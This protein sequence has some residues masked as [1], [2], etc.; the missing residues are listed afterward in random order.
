VGRHFAFFNIPASGHLIP[1]L[2]IAEELV[3]RGHRVTYA[4]TAEFAGT[5]ASTGASVLEYTST[6]DP[7]TIAPTG[8]DDWLARVLLGAA[9]EAIATAPAF[10]RHFANDPPDLVAYDISMQF[11]GRVLARKWQ[12]PSVQFYPVLASHQYFS[13]AESHGEGIFGDFM[14]ELRRFAELHDMADVPLSALVS[15]DAAALKVVTMP[16][17]FQTEAETFGDDYKFVG[18]TLRERDLRGTWQP[19]QS[20]HPVVLISLGTTFNKQLGFFRMCAEAFAGLP[21]HVVIAAGPGVDLA[22]VG[23]L[24]PNA[25]IHSWLS[26]QA[27]L[28]HAGAF[29][30]HGGAGSTMNG[31]YAGVPL[32]AIPQNG[33][34]QM[35]ADRTAELGLGRLLSSSQVTAESL[36]QAVLE[37]AAD[38]AT[39]ENVQRMRKHMHDAGGAPRAAD[40]ILAYLDRSGR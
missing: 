6:L 37:I 11:L 23:P 26:L 35:I 14:R 12:L 10:E 39:Q 16:K 38:P 18:I 4:A 33:D 7:R 30:C 13:D 22:E 32:V 8:A 20:G 28:E 36:R 27:V 3:R 2:G 17:E 19:P 15:D 29:V 31:L 24:P 34:E 25:E 5:V 21:W 1:T 9:Q 40:E